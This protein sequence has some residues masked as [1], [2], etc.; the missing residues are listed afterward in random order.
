MGGGSQKVRPTKG[1]RGGAATGGLGSQLIRRV[2]TGGAG[3]GGG[4]IGQ[5]AH[6]FTTDLGDGR[7]QQMQSVL[8]MDDLQEMM[9][10]AELNGR[11]FV[12][13]RQNVQV[14]SLCVSRQPRGPCEPHWAC[15]H[16]PPRAGPAR[17][18]EPRNRACA[19]CPACAA[20]GAAPSTPRS[21]RRSAS[22]S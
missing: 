22:A 4:Q 13:E 12:A 20:A 6:M 7:G 15:L 18:H 14:I 2:N 17:F 10:M 11:T 3:R 21:A 16:Q 1:K 9:E 19:L 5:Y 8:E